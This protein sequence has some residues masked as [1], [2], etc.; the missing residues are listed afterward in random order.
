MRMPRYKNIYKKGNCNFLFH[1]S[2]FFSRMRISEKKRSGLRDV[3]GEKKPDNY[4]FNVFS[5]MEISLYEGP[6]GGIHK[7]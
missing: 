7:I 3:F 2:D 4:L 1:N 5:V 6:T